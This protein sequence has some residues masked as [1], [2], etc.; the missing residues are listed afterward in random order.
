MA[1]AEPLA[2][3]D[4]VRLD[5]ELL[6]GEPGADPAHAR[7]HLVEADQKAV[8]LAPLGQAMPEPIGW[9]VGGQRG[10]ADRL[11]EERGDRARPAV[12]D[13]AI[14][15]LQ[16][17]LAARVGS[18]RARRDVQMI[19]EVRRVRL[20]QGAPA[21]EREGAHRRAVIRLRRRDHAPALG[22]APVHVV[23][24]GQ[25]QGRLVRLGPAR[26][27]PHARHLGRDDLE[28]AVGQPLLR[29]AGEVVVVEVG[30]AL[31]LLGRPPRRAPARRGRDT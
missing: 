6:V 11:A 15:L 18:P 24:P 7:D 2:H 26:D 1:G 12:L 28:H 5:R 16:R 27:E 13:E 21:G 8:L 14:E 17:G 29:L 9:R 25:L 4:D 20:L 23:D 30:D 31:G 19:G 3:G 10:G 22:L